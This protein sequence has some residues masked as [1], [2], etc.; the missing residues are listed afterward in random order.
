MSGRIFHAPFLHFHPGF[1]FS[2]VTERH[3]KKVN[4]SYPDVKSYDSAD[5]LVRDPDLELIVVNTP[6]NTHFDYARQSLLAGKHVLIEKPF[7]TSVAEAKE[8]FDLSEKLGLQVL[9]Y[10]NRRWD[11]DF[12]SVKHVL[13]NGKLGKLVEAHFRFDRYKTTIEQK[14]FKEEPIPGSGLAYNLAPH[15]LDQ[16]IS[17]FGKPLRCNKTTTCNRPHSKVDDYAFFHFIYPDDLNV[18]VYVS[19]LVARPLQ[20]FVLHGT[21]GSYVKDRTDIQEKQLD[22]GISPLDQNYGLELPGVEGEL[23]LIDESGKKTTQHVPSL[24]GNYAGLYDAV[25]QQLRNKDPFPV[26]KEHVICQMEIL[27][28]RNS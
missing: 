16:A 9:A 7:A 24:R 1:S 13:E 11:S 15:V 10:Q 26:T 22:Q 28:Q 4:Q 12:Q 27:E 21:K 5:S 25:Y 23:T 17:L 19:L 18:Y 6:N 8:L 3:Q 14:A 2:A 20:A